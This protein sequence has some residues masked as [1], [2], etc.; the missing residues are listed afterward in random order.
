MSI[1][2][3]TM[4]VLLFGGLSLGI[5]VGLTLAITGSL[6]LF[7]FKSIPVDRLIAQYSWN[8]MTTQELLALPLFIVMGEILFRTRISSS[9]FK[10][11]D[12]RF[13]E[14]GI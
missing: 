4:A 3:V 9:L 6:S 1:A 12:H 7:L 10:G 14:S 11:L 5:W 2:L 13:H 8:V